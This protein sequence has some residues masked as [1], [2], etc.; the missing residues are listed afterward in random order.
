[1]DDS[2]PQFRCTVMRCA[3]VFDRRSDSTGEAEARR[4]RLFTVRFNISGTRT[5]TRGLA[6]REFD[7]PYL[8]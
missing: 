3:V 5:I 1:M 8:D 6:S 2:P 7:L 4:T